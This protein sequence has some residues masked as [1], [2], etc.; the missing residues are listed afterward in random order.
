MEVKSKKEEV[1]TFGDMVRGCTSL[2]TWNPTAVSSAA[3]FQ[4]EG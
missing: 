4:G 2:S 3:K 1:T